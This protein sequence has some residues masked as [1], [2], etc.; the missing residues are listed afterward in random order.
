MNYIKNQFSEGL[1]PL[2]A[3]RLFFTSVLFAVLL[4]FN[5]PLFGQTAS[6]GEWTLIQEVENV[7]FYYQI[8]TCNNHS[9]LNLKVVNDNAVEV[10]GSWLLNMQD[11]TNA[12]HFPGMLMDMKAGVSRS[13]S[14]DMPDPNLA[15]PYPIPMADAANPTF[16]LTAQIELQ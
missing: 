7:K 8:S 3:H 4:L 1:K 2:L 9:F 11:E 15:I 12:Y 14:C 6:E 5:K 13:G 10:R 16:S